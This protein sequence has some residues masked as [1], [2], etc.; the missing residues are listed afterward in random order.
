MSAASSGSCVRRVEPGEVSPDEFGENVCS[1]GYVIYFVENE[2]L[3]ATAGLPEVRL[4]DL[5]HSFASM[6]AAS[7]A[8]L[9]MIGKLL[10]HSQPQTTPA[11]RA[12]GGRPGQRTQQRGLGQDRCGDRVAS[13]K[14]RIAT[15]RRSDGVLTPL[16]L[17]GV[18]R[19][20]TPIT[21]P[22]PA[23]CG[24]VLQGAG[25]GQRQ[26]RLWRR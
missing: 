17:R 19:Q 14:R 24:G 23:R 12:P 2:R 8:S 5:R 22:Y 6:A 3:R 26:C 21:R 13:A 11:I 10:G 4:H 20:K 18:T 1:P 16:G 15:F 7:G 9:P 25:H